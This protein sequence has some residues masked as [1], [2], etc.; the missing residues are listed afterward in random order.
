MDDWHRYERENQGGPIWAGINQ[1]NG[2]CMQP[3]CTGFPNEQLF[4]PQATPIPLPEPQPSNRRMLPRLP[5]EVWSSTLTNSPA[6]ICQVPTPPLIRGNR[7]KPR[8]HSTSSRR[9]TLTDS[10]RWQICQYYVEHPFVKQREI[11]GKFHV[12]YC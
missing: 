6:V 12:N 8:N 1:Q 11:G 2:F 10:D 9:K 5:R 4:I 3:I 7:T